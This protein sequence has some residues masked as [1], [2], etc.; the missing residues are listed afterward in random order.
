MK[1]VAVIGASDASK[2]E[3]NLAESVGTLLAKNGI[4]L[5]SGGLTGVMEASCRGAFLS[6]GLTIGIVPRTEGNPYLSVIMKTRMDQA[7][8][9]ILVGSS[10]AAI[11]IGGGYGTLSEIA[12]A[13]KNKIPVFGLLTWDI[14]DIIICKTPEEAV[15]RAIKSISERAGDNET[16]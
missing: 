1:Q 9:F 10:D 2:E 4:C 15:N 13:L 6:G 8:N 7:R 16:P 11:A 14:P 5:L 3:I 12:Y